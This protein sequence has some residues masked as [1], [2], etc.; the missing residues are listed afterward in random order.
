MRIVLWFDVG[1][2]R[3]TTFNIYTIMAISCG[4]M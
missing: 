4:L 3:Y 1:S 2:E